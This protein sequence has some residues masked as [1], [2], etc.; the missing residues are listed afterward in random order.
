VDDETVVL[1]VFVLLVVAGL[2]L[3]L[4]AMSNRRYMRELAHRERMAMIERGIAPAPES[5]EVQ[6]DSSPGIAAATSAAP[7]PRR[8]DRFRTV[9]V[10]MIGLGVGLGF[11]IG[12]TGGS[13]EVALGVSG[14]WV[15]LG[16]ASLVNYFLVRGDR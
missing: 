5:D 7:G 9:G 15:S 13:P 14:A 6:F 10:A 11:L 12:L 3:L 4:M 2:T 1:A 16:A 8:G